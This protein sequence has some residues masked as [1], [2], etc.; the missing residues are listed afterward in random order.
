MCLEAAFFRHFHNADGEDEVGEAAL[1]AGLDDEGGGLVAN[2]IVEGPAFLF[3][4]IDIC[5]MFFV[6]LVNISVGFRGLRHDGCALNWADLKNAFEHGDGIEEAR[7]EV[8]V[9]EGGVGSGHCAD[10]EVAIGDHDLGEVTTAGKG[11]H[12]LRVDDRGFEHLAI[13]LER[14][15]RDRLSG[16]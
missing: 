7:F 1:L 6:G 12:D 5:E 2:L 14:G 4:P 10:G 8:E 9:D 16:Q 11:L 3:F 15:L 13:L